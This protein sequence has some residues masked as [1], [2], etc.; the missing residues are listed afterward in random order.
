MGVATGDLLDGADWV[1]LALDQQDNPTY[2][3]HDGSPF[4]EAPVDFAATFRDS[5]WMC[6]KPIRIR[7]FN[8]NPLRVRPHF[9]VPRHHHSL[10][11]MVIVLQGT[12]SIEYDLE[13]GAAD[14]PRETVVIHPGEYF[15]S[16]AGTPYTMTAG[17]EGVT[18]I[19]TWPEPLPELLTY[20]HD[21]GWVP[22]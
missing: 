3:W 14:T 20:W 8:R 1:P 5:M 19:E 7:R 10:D 9:V 22:R 21:E 13:A 15:L 11:E 6:A 2:F 12:Y 18:Y 17:A 4:T 16:R